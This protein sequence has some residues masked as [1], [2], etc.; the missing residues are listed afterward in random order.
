MGKTRIK[1]LVKLGEYRSANSS[2]V[3][4]A[5]KTNVKLTAGLP[6]LLERRCC[7][8]LT[9]TSQMREERL[10]RRH[11][12]IT[13]PH[14]QIQCMDTFLLT[15]LLDTAYVLRCLAGRN[16]MTNKGHN[17]TFSTRDVTGNG[18]LSA[19]TRRCR[20][21]LGR[22]GADCRCHCACCRIPPTAVQVSCG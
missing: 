9:V 14:L 17:T 6:V 16:L 20:L 2:I 22:R 19:S 12:E 8:C 4:T 10:S 5:R 13:C 11:G 1:G 7:P 15:A 18:T 21:T 3:I